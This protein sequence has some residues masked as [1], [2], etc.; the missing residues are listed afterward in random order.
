V[1]PVLACSSRS[2]G[3]A[4]APAPRC[5]CGRR[6][7]GA[8]RARPGTTAPADANRRRPTRAVR[9]LIRVSTTSHQATQQACVPRAA[10]PSRSTAGIRD[11][12][13]QSGPLLRRGR[14]RPCS[15]W[16]SLPG[17][18]GCGAGRSSVVGF[19]GRPACFRLHLVVLLARRSF[20]ARPLQSEVPVLF[21]EGAVMPASSAAASAASF[22]GRRD[23]QERVATARSTC[24]SS[25]LTDRLGVERWR[26]LQIEPH[27]RCR[28]ELHPTA[29]AP[30]DDQPVTAPD[31]AG[32]HGCANRLALSRSAPLAVPFPY[33]KADDDR[34]PTPSKL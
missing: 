3:S 14:A 4:P 23:G 2:P 34:G 10:C 32:H 15:R 17:R 19:R 12:P 26:R 20:V 30:A 18:R 5:A 25:D 8:A 1:A 11:Q 9:S 28:T 27:R 33:R 16:R 21:D 7:W 24:R 31:S 22:G 13:R 29:A 6:C